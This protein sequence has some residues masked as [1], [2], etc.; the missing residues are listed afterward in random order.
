MRS[1]TTLVAVAMTA[2]LGLAACGGG[3]DDT[4]STAS[5][6]KET[7]PIRIALM[8]INS[9]P[10]AVKGGENGLKLAVDQ[11]NASGGI[12]GRQV[13][14]K[15]FDTEIT[16]QAAQNA[17]RLAL[18]YKPSVFI[19][20]GVSSGLKAS[21]PSINQAGVPV[22]HTTLAKLTNPKELGT[23]LTFRLQATTAQF[24]TGANEYLFKDKGVKKMMIIH[25][26]DA[27]P[28]EGG[29]SIEE[30]AKAAGVTTQQRGILPAATDV[31]EPL[32]ATKSLGAD[33]IWTWGY[34]PTDAL[35]IK[36][37]AANGF[38]GQI[39]TFSAGTA[40]RNNLVPKE[41]MTDKILSVASTCAANVLT[42]PAAKKY[43]ADYKK[44]FGMDVTEA[45]N[46]NYYDAVNLFAAAV[47]KS[48]SSEPAA[49]AKALR[50]VKLD[51]VCGPLKSDENQNL[52]SNVPILNFPNGEPKL[53]KIVENVKSP[54]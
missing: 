18:E 5:G 34:A 10:N 40:A 45:I 51:G 14:F 20:Y 26:E 25:T 44:A 19:G 15:I 3:A 7:G 11:L 27:A 1:R 17:T 53:V 48:G 16:P 32:L 35:T 23:D 38:T 9:G 2:T 13:E 37:A 50:E 41:L 33:A 39:M 54:F 24:A 8:T 47:K 22:I 6:P 4:A 46:N 28:T 29:K 31:T 12:G 36:T 30:N 49:V 43:Q 42:T 52:I 21:I